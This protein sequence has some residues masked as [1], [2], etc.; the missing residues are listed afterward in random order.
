MAEQPYTPGTQVR[1]RSDSEVSGNL[2]RGFGDI[3][4]YKIFKPIMRTEKFLNVILDENGQIVKD[5]ETGAY[6]TTG[7]A[8]ESNFLEDVKIE[9]R[10]LPIPNF[11]SVG[12]TTALM[13]DHYKIGARE[14][15]AEVADQVELLILDIE[16]GNETGI[17]EKTAYMQKLYILLGSLTDTSKATGELAYL[18]KTEIGVNRTDFLQRQELFE[19][20]KKSGIS[21]MLEGLSHRGGQKKTLNNWGR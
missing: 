8:Y 11:F 1:P 17:E 14:L 5:E 16:Q 21:K 19:D 2:M 12:L 4:E 13:D 7:E 9:T 10:H 18:A 15:L 3:T 20:K 6:L